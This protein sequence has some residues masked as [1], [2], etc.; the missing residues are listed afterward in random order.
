MNLL[1][2]IDIQI[3][4]GVAVA[5][6][7]IGSAAA[8]LKSTKKPR[9]LSFPPHPLSSNRRLVITRL[10]PVE[11]RRTIYGFAYLLENGMA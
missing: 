6:V 2:S 5:L 8:Y 3:I 9:G 4:L 10:A 7:A 11:L 1:E